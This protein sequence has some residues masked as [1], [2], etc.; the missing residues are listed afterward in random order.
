MPAD[1]ST[2]SPDL[3]ECA[4]L[5]TD[6]LT[7]LASILPSDEF[8][9]LPPSPSQHKR[10]SLRIPISFDRP[11]KVRVIS[12]EPI[13]SAE[14]SSSSSQA[15]LIEV[16][17]L[18]P[19]LLQLSLPPTYPL[20]AEPNVEV[21]QSPWLNL[22]ANQDWLRHRLSQM[23][24]ESRAE[25]LYLWADWIREGM[26]DEIISRQDDKEE[27]RWRPSLDTVTSSSASAEE[28]DCIDLYEIASLNPNAAS[29][30]SR[31]L[32]S[33]LATYNSSA[34]TLVFEDSTFYCSICLEERKGR[35]CTRV[36]ACSHIFCTQCLTDYVTIAMDDSGG[37]VEI[38]CPDPECTKRSAT[39]NTRAADDEKR[40]DDSKACVITDSELLL[41]VGQ[42]RFR[43]FAARRA[44]TLAEADPTAAFCPV[45]GCGAVVVG[46][47]EDTGTTFEALRECEQCG[48]AFCRW[49]LKAWHGKTPC[50]L[51]AVSKLASTWL[52]SAP[53]SPERAALVRKYGLTNITRLVAAYEEERANRAWLS[54][55][56]TRC[57]HC[58]CSVE[59]SEGC[60]HLTCVR[61][62]MHFCFLCGQRLNPAR[63]YAH[64]N[65]PGVPC[66]Q[67]LFEGLLRDGTDQEDETGGQ[68]ED[69]DGYVPDAREMRWAR[70]AAG[71]GGMQQFWVGGENEDVP[72]AALFAGL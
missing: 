11:R 42:E 48:F 10:I 39:A 30:N 38:G 14:S 47:K 53:D 59:K 70:A 58:S 56:T 52:A 8:E 5:Q 23:W 17:H 19:L 45:V 60:N 18:P 46:R 41:L 49:C 55:R 64:F 26:W 51:S 9:E 15:Q 44:K 43:S 21:L 33:L 6:E 24:D 3:E 29:T 71:G 37:G 40:D 66:Y 62:G 57:P 67:K 4:A 1:L 63:P 7:A 69:A 28:T 2:T 32:V 27:V 16:Q 35:R 34:E 12:L 22:P 25:V 54:A 50:E 65:T 72:L 13:G 36:L 20:S 31:S 68:V 61:C